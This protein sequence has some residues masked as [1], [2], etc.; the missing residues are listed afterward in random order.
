MKFLILVLFPYISLSQALNSENIVGNRF[1]Q[2]S[3][4]GEVIRK[5]YFRKSTYTNIVYMPKKKAI[6]KRGTYFVSKDTIYLTLEKQKAK[7]R[8][9]LD[10]AISDSI[11]L[12]VKDFTTNDPIPFCDVIGF[13][14][15]VITRCTTNF[16]GECLIPK[17]SYDS[18]TFKFVGYNDVS[19]FLYKKSKV[20]SQ[21]SI[22]MSPKNHQ[23]EFQYLLIRDG[24][25]DDD[26]SDEKLKSKFY[27]KNH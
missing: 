19:V 4:K 12:N 14:N 2:Y 13:H 21:I 3:S 8:I 22:W 27:P 20:P 7:Y 10:F 17:F 18:V 11:E 6:I 23:W 5:F 15:N 16:I 9:R 24:Y 26:H 25:L 1:V